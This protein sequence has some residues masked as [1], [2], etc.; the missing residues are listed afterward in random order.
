VRDAPQAEPALFNI[1]GASDHQLAHRAPIDLSN[2]EHVAYGL[3]EM[4]A[5]AAEPPSAAV[6]GAPGRTAD[7]GRARP[8]ARTHRL[9]FAYAGH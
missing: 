3:F 1:T 7:Q 6:G 4:M 5:D 8:H 2:E 9:L